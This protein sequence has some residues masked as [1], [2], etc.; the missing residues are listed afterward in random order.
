MKKLLALFSLWL[1]VGFTAFGQFTSVTATITDS[2]SQTWNNGH[3]SAT[4]YN[5]FPTNAPSIN[6]TPLTNNQ[7]NLSGS[8]NGSGTFTQSMA[9]NS[10][11]APTGTQWVFTICPNA[12][13]QCSVVQTAVSGGSEDIS[14]NLSSGLSQLRF[15]ASPTAYGYLDSEISPTPRPGG[16]Y[17]N[18]ATLFTRVWTGFAWQNIGGSSGMTWPAGGAGIPNY[19]GSSSWGTTYNTGNTIPANFLP[20]T[21]NSNTTGNS[22]TATALAGSP[23]N[24]SGIQ[25]A[26]GITVSG[27][28]NCTNQLVT[29]VFGRTGNVIATTGDYTCAQVTGCA[30]GLTSQVAT[31]TVSSGSI[32]CTSATCT[33]LSGTLSVTTP[34]SS[35]SNLSFTLSWTDPQ[36][37]FCVSSIYGFTGGP[38]T[39]TLLGDGVNLLSSSTSWTPTLEGFT[40]NGPTTFSIWYVCSAH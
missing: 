5:P 18:V 34:S 35:Y 39:F 31:P 25:V 21:I 36:S 15:P 22:A 28:A 10:Q 37:S 29:N 7:L 27:N 16:G 1:C 40:G 38:P 19:S 33:S 14:S 4:L 23:T 32:S 9:D 3:W 8:M 12:S 2:D 24:C 17:F 6:G 13:A 20:A 11:V 26:L 30:S